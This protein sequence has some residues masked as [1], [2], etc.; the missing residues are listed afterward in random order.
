MTNNII[1]FVDDLP[2]YS[3]PANAE[4]PNSK[5]LYSLIYQ[6]IFNKING[7][8]TSDCIEDCSAKNIIQFKFGNKI[9]WSDNT[10]LTAKDFF[11]T[12]KHIFLSRSN[13]CYY[14]DFIEGVK[15]F[16][17]GDGSIDDIKIWIKDNIFFAKT[18]VQDT[19]KDVFSRIN[20]APMKY[21]DDG[22]FDSSVTSGGYYYQSINSHKILLKKNLHYKLLPNY[23][24]I[25]EEKDVKKQIQQ[26]ENGQLA[27]SGFTSL[28]FQELSS[29][30]EIYELPSK[31]SFRVIFDS[32]FFEI[33]YKKKIKKDIVTELNRYNELLKFITIN[34]NFSDNYQSEDIAIEEKKHI[35]VLSPNYFPNNLIVDCLMQSMDE[36]NFI[37]ECD[38]LPFKEY[39]SEDW[40]KYDIVLELVEPITENPIDAFIEQIK[41]IK[42][43]YRSEYVSLIN[44]YIKLK[45]DRKKEKANEINQFIQIYSRVF[46]LGIFRQYYIKS[47]SLPNVEVTDTGLINITKMFL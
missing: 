20:F 6:P 24:E 18:V 7:N 25:I 17:Y 28:G 22:E 30:K 39:L 35:K 29:N 12:L 23:I 13:C 44:Q 15:E 26:I 34:N 27:Y 33:V 14:L 31:I 9:F 46:D 11:Y 42:T 38:F 43:A 41:F 2:Q 47:S 5:L 4:D 1:F 19:Y 32:E 16:I 45:N 36:Y 3:V 10:P 40:E 8:F 37:F 21:N